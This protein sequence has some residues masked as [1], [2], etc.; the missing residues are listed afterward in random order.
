MSIVGKTT[1][2]SSLPSIK[3]NSG[4]HTDVYL[5]GKRVRQ[6]R[7]EADGT[8]PASECVTIGGT[9]QPLPHMPSGREEREL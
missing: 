3:I 2:F 6:P 4:T 8:L 9:L 5:M 1:D 7:R